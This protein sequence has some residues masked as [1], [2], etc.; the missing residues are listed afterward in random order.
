MKPLKL[1]VTV[2]V[3]VVLLYVTAAAALAA[4]MLQP[5]ERFSQVM[6]RMPRQLFPV[7][8]FRPL[9]TVA[10]AGSLGVGDPAPDW[11]LVTFDRASHVRLSAHRDRRPV[12]LVFGSYT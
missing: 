12:A 5:P 1:L 4:A 3:A 2:V 6:A 11:T 9:W 8:P 7:L 10:R